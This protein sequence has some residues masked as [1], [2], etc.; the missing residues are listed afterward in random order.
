MEV[1]LSALAET[2]LLH[3]T[4]YIQEQWGKLIR[5]KFINEFSKKVSQISN[6]PNSC[7][8]SIEFK[9][10]YKCV[11]SKQSTF[12]YRVNSNLNEIE[13]ITIFDTRQDPRTLENEIQ[14]N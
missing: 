2:K 14:N 1:Y 3:L 9:G 7:P 10:L 11:V 13:I 8:E 6:Q 5:D 4:N 12:Y